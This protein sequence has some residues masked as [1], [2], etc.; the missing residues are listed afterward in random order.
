[1]K[2]TTHLKDDRLPLPFTGQFEA[3]RNK[4]MQGK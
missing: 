4:D 3:G 2:G 1:M